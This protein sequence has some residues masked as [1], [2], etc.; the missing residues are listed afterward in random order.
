MKNALAFGEFCRSNRVQQGLTLRKFCRLHQF[1]PA[2]ISRL[3]RGIVT[4]PKDDQVRRSYASA[5]GL[6]QGTE[7]WRRFFELADLCAG[8]IPEEFA[9]DEA[10]LKL[11]PLF[12]RTVHGADIDEGEL[13]SLI[14]RLKREL[15]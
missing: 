12:F 13:R 11:L 4:P 14:E 6:I 15:G 8:R 5:L 1:D 7:E 10:V 9:R 2:Y 3:E